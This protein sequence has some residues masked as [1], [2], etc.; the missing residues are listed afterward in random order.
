MRRD[1]KLT[2]LWILKQRRK[3]ALRLDCLSERE[4]QL[5]KIW[6]TGV[7]A[8]GRT[9]RV[10]CWQHLHKCGW[11]LTKATVLWRNYWVEGVQGWTG[12]THETGDCFN[13]LFFQAKV[14][15]AIRH[16]VVL[17]RKS[18]DLKLIIRNNSSW[19]TYAE[20]Y[21][22]PRVSQHWELRLTQKGTQ[23]CKASLLDF[24][25]WEPGDSMERIPTEQCLWVCG[26]DRLLGLS[27]I[28]QNNSYQP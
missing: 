12:C 14:L 17:V 5:S 3:K 20:N 6:L 4:L 24:I 7:V 23:S 8:W 22:N 26:V 16:I 21:G 9:Q 27:A 28:N 10:L 15:I 13:W 2:Q 1:A 19:S 18:L 11:P 25:L